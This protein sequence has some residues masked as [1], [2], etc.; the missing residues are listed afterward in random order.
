MWREA[1]TRRKCR[2]TGAN[3]E[4]E[5]FCWGVF[6]RRK[7]FPFSVERSNKRVAH[8][9]QRVPVLSG[10]I[11]DTQRLHVHVLKIQQVMASSGFTLPRTSRNIRRSYMHRL[12]ALP[13]VLHI[14]FRPSSVIHIHTFVRRFVLVSGI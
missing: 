13:A 11:H 4:R 7:W 10:R 3:R 12:S 9:S 2:D 6:L 1:E 5:P 8:C 14:S